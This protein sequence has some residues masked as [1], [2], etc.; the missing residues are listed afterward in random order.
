MKIIID[1]YEDLVIPEEDETLGELLVQ[2]ESWINENKRVVIQVRLEGKSLSEEDKKILFNKKV[3]EFKTLELY[4]ANLWQWAI[5]S[6]EEI[7][8]YLPEIAKEV[9]KVSLLIQKGNHKSAF[10]LLERCIGLW[11]EANEVLEKIEKI[12][13]LDYTK[14]FLE[15]NVLWKVEKIVQFLK[16]AKRA[17]KDNDLLTLADVLEYELAP[18]IR[19]ERKLVGEIINM[20]KYQMN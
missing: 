4:T 8:S 12:F 16:E 9:E 10:S 13:A 18:R 15:R 7:K 19:E 6:L 14:I 20:L 1:G 11:D 3:S 17:I 2:L 5:N